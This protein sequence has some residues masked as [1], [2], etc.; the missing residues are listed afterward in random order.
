MNSPRTLLN[1]EPLFGDPVVYVPRTMDEGDAFR[2]TSCEEANDIQA[3]YADF[4]QV[5]R[6]VRPSG[7]YLRFQFYNMLPL[8]AANQPYRRPL[9][10]RIFLDP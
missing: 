2:L 3:D 9:S 6:D 5:E 10:I 7:L 4:V 8:H 1:S